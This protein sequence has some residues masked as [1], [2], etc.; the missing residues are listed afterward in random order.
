MTE[1]GTKEKN[2]ITIVKH[3]FCY[4]SPNHVFLTKQ[5]PMITNL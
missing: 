1:K 3:T 5:S 2:Q 4:F